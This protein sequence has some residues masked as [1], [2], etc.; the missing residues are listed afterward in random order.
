MF[1]SVF[2]ISSGEDTDRNGQFD[3]NAGQDCLANCRACAGVSD[4]IVVDRE[5]AEELLFMGSMVQLGFC[6]VVLHSSS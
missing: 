3:A 1:L 6:F 4:G 5:P 2:F